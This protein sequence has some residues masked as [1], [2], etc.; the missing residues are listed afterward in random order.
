[1]FIYDNEVY[2][3][4]TELYYLNPTYFLNRGG[5]MTK[6]CI[7]ATPRQMFIHELVEFYD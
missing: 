2:L 1:M 3:I 7:G 4:L 5:K 6:K